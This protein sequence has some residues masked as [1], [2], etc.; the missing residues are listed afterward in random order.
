VRP[1]FGIFFWIRVVGRE[2][3]PAGAA[4]VCANHSSL[5]DPVLVALAMGIDNQTHIV[6]K[7]EVFRIPVVSALLRKL[8]MI[9]VDRDIT[10]ISTIK[11]VLGYLKKGEKVAI[12]PEGTRRRNDDEV[13]PK[14]GAVK[15]AEHAEVQ[16]IPVYIPR[17]KRMFKT[18]RIVIGEPYSIAKQK[19]KR[20]SEEYAQ[21]ADAVMCKIKG[22]GP[23]IRQ[24]V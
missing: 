4:M 15:I 21:L 17:K 11:S 1:L 9:S 7:V 14:I 16:V 6:G 22:L 18:I 24:P 3:I 20:A 2:N 10:D 19:G 12:V 5:L 8:E 13:V 23:Q